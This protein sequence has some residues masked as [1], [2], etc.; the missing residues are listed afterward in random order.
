MSRKGSDLIIHLHDRL[1]ARGGADRHLWGILEQLQAHAPTELLVGWDDSSLPE[2]ERACVGPWSR[3]K[4]LERGGLSQRGGEAACQKLQKALNA[5]NSAV[6]HVHNIM[7][8][9]LLNIATATGRA[10]LTIQ[11]HRYFC[12]GL[13]KLKSSGVICSE[14][15]G[16]VCLECFEDT[17]YGRR[18]LALTRARL[19]AAA[20]M[21][22]VLV[23][24]KYMA[25]ELLAAWQAEGL[26]HPPIEVLPPFVHGLQ[27]L[28][29]PSPGEYHLLAS[30]LV[31][32][33][34]VRQ[35]LAV[36]RL[37][38]LPLLVAGDGAL[39]SEVEQAAFESG[40]RVRYVGWA[41]RDKLS[42]L[43]AG[44]R[45]LWM[46]SLWAEPFGIAGLEALAAGVPVVASRVGGVP[47]WL[48]QGHIGFLIPPGDVEG[49]A[50]AARRLERD[51][52]MAEE[53]G[54]AGAARVAQKYAPGPLMLK[55]NKFYNQAG[56]A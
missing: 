55:L 42:R 7:D 20:S 48:D 13:G 35:A 14:V 34:G 27:P 40:G 5:S 26:I 15:M 12:P 47:E 52:S 24:S 46:P 6:I 4:G 50:D 11:D 44:A 30:R 18:L 10:L 8:P 53:M 21:R 28:A 25:V 36:A 3:L 17:D 9:G 31:E 49:L 32:R 22:L 29:R 54:R 37:T 56:S 23:L 16:E 2:A 39:R 38:E 19:Q 45:S 43:L 51:P 33:K 1:S 41:D